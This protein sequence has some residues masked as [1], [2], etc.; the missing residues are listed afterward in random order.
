ME[1]SNRI[2]RGRSLLYYPASLW[3]PFIM[4]SQ[5]KAEPSPFEKMQTLARRV[6]SV[7]KAEIDRRAAE[8]KKNKKARR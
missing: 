6:M 4:E 1:I 3:H 5:P 7:P 2:F 8:A